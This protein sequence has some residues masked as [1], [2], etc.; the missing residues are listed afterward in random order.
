MLQRNSQSH[1]SPRHPSQGQRLRAKE[2]LVE[3]EMGGKSKYYPLI[4]I[5]NRYLKQCKCG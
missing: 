4:L 5:W 2:R 1:T 3:D